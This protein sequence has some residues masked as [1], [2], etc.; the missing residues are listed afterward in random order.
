MPCKVIPRTSRGAEPDEQPSK[1]GLRKRTAQQMGSDGRNLQDTRRDTLT[2][3]T[4]RKATD[5]RAQSSSS[6]Q[7]TKKRKRASL[8]QGWAR[9][10][11]SRE[12]LAEAILKEDGTRYLRK[13]EPV[14]E[15]AQSVIS[16]QPKGNANTA[17]VDDWEE[18][19]IRAAITLHCNKIRPR[20]LS[21]SM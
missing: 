5:A 4:R 11:K 6:R 21:Y 17:L 1:Y 8:G 9:S 19:T 7:S 2:K 18:R 15:G 14:Y 13:Y 10:N 12:W 20:S 16:W 3:E